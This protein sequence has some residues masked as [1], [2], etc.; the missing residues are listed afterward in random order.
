MRFSRFFNFSFLLFALL[1]TACGSSNSS[2]SDPISPSVDG[3]SVPSETD[4]PLVE[5]DFDDEDR[6]SSGSIGG[7]LSDVEIG[8][9]FADNTT[10]LAIYSYGRSSSYRY[11]S[12]REE[13][14]TIELNSVTVGTFNFVTHKPGDSILTIYDD[15]DMIVYRNIVRVRKAYDEVGVAQAIYDFDAYEGFGLFGKHRLNFTNVSPLTGILGGTDD[16]EVTPMNIVFEATYEGINEWHDMHEFVLD[17]V[18]ANEGSQTKV[19]RML[20]SRTGDFII[21]YYLTGGEDVM[22]NLFF[23]TSLK[24]IHKDFFI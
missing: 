10:Y 6:I 7:D 19:S 17:V 23:P 18:S 22:L 12:S 1:A 3:T 20:V 2:G 15:N 5:I 14:L 11:V 24:D 8:R 21:L 4:E 13:S 16:I 9:Y